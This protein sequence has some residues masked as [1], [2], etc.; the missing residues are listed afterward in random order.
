M[1]EM[2]DSGLMN[3]PLHCE[4]VLGLILTKYEKAHNLGNLFL[5]N[6]SYFEAVN[7]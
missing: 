5:S 4:Q 7:T 6:L 3:G 2:D 1:L